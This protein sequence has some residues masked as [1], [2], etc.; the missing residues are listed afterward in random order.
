MAGITIAIAEARLTSYLAAEDKIL[1]GQKVS[2]AG[3]EASGT[4]NMKFALNGA[5]TI[6][7]LDGANVEIREEV[8][9]TNI[10][11]FGLTTEQAEFERRM[12]KRTPRTIYEQNPEIRLVV[13]SIKDG[14][15]TNGDKNLFQPII[16]DL[17]DHHRDP[18]LH[19]IDLE[20]Y[21]R[22]QEQVDQTYRNK[23][24]WYKKAIYNVAGMGKFSSDRT[25]QQYASEIWGI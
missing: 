4:G 13:D 5:L 21:I 18:Y 1:L 19:L 7:T 23:R 9:P 6:G 25:I 12:P 2:L 8:G 16:D 3:K 17:M 14:S 24:E 15:F 11:I 22:C 20:D 10:F